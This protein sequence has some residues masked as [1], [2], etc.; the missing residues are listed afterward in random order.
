MI[1]TIEEKYDF[2][3]KEHS[4]MYKKLSI[5]LFDSVDFDEFIKQYSQDIKNLTKIKFKIETIKPYVK[6]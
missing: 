4:E 2:L 5:H 3:T 6:K 1:T